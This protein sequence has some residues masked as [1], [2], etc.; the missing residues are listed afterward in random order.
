M[1]H[2]KRGLSYPERATCEIIKYYEA[3]GITQML[4]EADD[5]VCVIVS[6]QALV[7]PS[8]QHAR[9][10]CTKQLELPL[11][12]RAHKP[13]RARKYIPGSIILE[14]TTDCI[15]FG[16]RTMVDGKYIIPCMLKS[17]SLFGRYAD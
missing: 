8:E 12:Y 9:S 2:D 14:N 17:P 6:R 11:D 16:L 10:Y 15:A 3:T 4:I 7:S 1:F 13:G 5:D